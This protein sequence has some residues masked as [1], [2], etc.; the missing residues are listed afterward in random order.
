MSLAVFMTFSGG[1]S[2]AD[3]KG[4]LNPAGMGLI[5]PLA[6]PLAGMLPPGIALMSGEVGKVLGSKPGM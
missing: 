1:R 6:Q 4:L 2:T 5:W 3:S